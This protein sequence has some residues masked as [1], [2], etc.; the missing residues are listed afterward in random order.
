MAR[1]RRGRVINGWVIL[2]KPRD[3]TSTDAVAAVRRAFDAAKAGHAGTLDPLA[4]GIL[5]I[6]LGE[7]TKVVSMVMDQAKRKLR[8][9]IFELRF[10]QVS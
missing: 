7:A 4:T 3:V 9:Q 5:P 10:F 6:A 8:L 2:D 1:R